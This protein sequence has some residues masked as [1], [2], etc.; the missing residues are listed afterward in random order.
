MVKCRGPGSYSGE[1][2]CYKVRQGGKDF[3]ISFGRGLGIQKI[4]KSKAYDGLYNKLGTRKGELSFQACK[5]EG[6]EKQG[7]RSCQMQKEL[8]PKGF[9]EGNDIKECE[10]N[11]LLLSEDYIRGLEIREDTSLAGHTFY[12]KL[13]QQ[14]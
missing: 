6:K 2:L 5:N 4:I 3:V 13:K 10:E 9:S 14:K 11:I 12:A 8:R 7:V 1:R